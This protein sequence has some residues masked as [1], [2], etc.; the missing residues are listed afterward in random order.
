MCLPASS[1][2]VATS[3]WVVF[4]VQT[5]TA[6]HCSRSSWI[7][8]EAWP[9]NRT[10]NACERSG[11][12]S[13]NLRTFTRQ[14]FDRMAAWIPA[15]PPAPTI[16][17]LC[18]IPNFLL[19]QF[20]CARECSSLEF[21]HKTFTEETLPFSRANAAV[22]PSRRLRTAFRLP[23]ADQWNTRI[24]LQGVAAQVCIPRIIAGGHRAG[25]PR[26]NVEVIHVVSMRRD[27][28]VVSVSN[29]HQI[30]V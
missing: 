29:Q 13:T 28:R 11:S 18:G 26:E 22:W 15:T 14:S 2:C 25:A 16:P 3:S 7:D 30:A 24:A 21:P 19:S 12:T 20:P 1:T 17:M 9:P 5:K 27:N 8:P 23:C 6:S 4:G 10:A